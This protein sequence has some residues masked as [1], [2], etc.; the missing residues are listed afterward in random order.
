MK[1]ALYLA[2]ATFVSTGAALAQTTA[3]TPPGA[4]QTAPTTQT[5]PGGVQT[6]PMAHTSPGARIGATDKDS[7][8]AVQSRGGN[9]TDIPAKGSNSFTEGQAK[10][11]IAD[12]GYTSIAELKKDDDGVWRGQ[13]QKGGSSVNVWVDYKGNVGEQR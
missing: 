5:L 1:P 11:R 12:R 4:V 3:Q 8:A 13:A 6:A 9:D 2:L 10:G 7:N